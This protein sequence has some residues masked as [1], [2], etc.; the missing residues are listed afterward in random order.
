MSFDDLH[1]RFITTLDAAANS[2]W[3]RFTEQMPDSYFRETKLSTQLAHL[4]LLAAGAASGVDQDL[5]VRSPDG[6]IWTFL[7]NQSRPGQLGGFL[8]RLPGD[9]PLTSARAFTSKDGHWVI[10]IFEFS[11]SGQPEEAGAEETERLS[12]GLAQELKERFRDHLSHCEPGYLRATTAALAQRHF[13]LLQ[14]AEESGQAAID[15]EAVDSSTSNLRM[16]VEESGVRRMFERVARYLGLRQVDIERAYLTAFGPSYHYL[17]FEIRGAAPEQWPEL[18]RDIERLAYLSERVLNLWQTHP[19]WSLEESEV[20]H[21]LLSVA[22]QVLLPKDPLRFARARLEAAVSRN[23]QLSRQLV[24]LF[25]G[26]GDQTPI[27]EAVEQVERDDD[28]MI[29][30]TCLR[31]IQATRRSNLGVAGR[32]SL[33]A[34]LEPALFCEPDE[35]LPFAILFAVGRAFEGFHVRFQE[36][37][38]GGMR[39]VCPRSAEAHSLECERLFRE[40][41]ALARA[42][43][44]KNKDIPEGGSKAVVLVE[45][46]ASAAECGRVFADALLDL[47]LGDPAEFLYLGPDENVSNELIEWISLRAARR[48]HPLPATFMSSKPG[49]GINH[50]AYGITSEGITVYLEVVLRQAGIEPKT[51]P[52]TVTLTGGPDGDVAGNQI[53]ILLTRYP[54]TARVVGIADGSGVAE[55]PDGLNAQELLRL[56]EEQLPIASFD[57]SRLGPN[58]R[59]VSL[60]EPGGVQLRNTL[61]HRLVC[62]AFVPG[63]GRPGTIHEQNW[64]QF[65]QPDGRPI[66][67]LIVE[68]ANLFLTDGARTLLGQHGVTIIKDSSANKCGVIC[69]SFEI[70]A[71]MLL[72]QEEFLAHKAAF[73]EQVVQRLRQLALLEAELLFQER[74]RRPDLGLPELSLRLSGVMLRAAE[75][76]AHS[77]EDPLQD[78]RFGTRE[79]LLDYLPPILRQLAGDRVDRIPLE[80]RQRIVACALA[81]KIVYREGITFL[82]D[83]PA[84]AMKELAISYLVGER[85]IGRLVAQLEASDLPD[86]GQICQLLELGGARTL[87]RLRDL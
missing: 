48:G 74:R 50:K 13:A 2:V 62:D 79:V 26:G 25:S 87:M 32:R 16:V 67:P 37:A 58:G 11:G 6:N 19:G 54:K 70:L 82:E 53:K 69:S 30:Q 65:L 9:R 78:Q 75:A 33:A 64:S 85:H 59:V 21:F 36:V 80:Y 20:L 4:H 39:L 44:L 35:T 72:S 29:F 77:I 7:T 47:T 60:N 34:R 38:R 45:P 55:D 5:V 51:D 42:Q 8:S 41:Y 27:R 66:S 86:A 10:D 71:S 43:H 63:G 17:G 12:V 46:E 1:H 23:E 24:A 31:A 81:G 76:V 57:P 61:H 56:T 18:T 15:W 52:F 68:G 14:V 28:R 84:E 3:D 40:A 22:H 49:A 73:V 83:L